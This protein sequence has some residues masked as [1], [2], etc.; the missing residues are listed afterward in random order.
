M[1]IKDG[2]GGR[3][4]ANLYPYE[5]GDLFRIETLAINIGSNDLSG[6]EP[7][8]NRRKGLSVRE[9]SSLFSSG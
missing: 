7:M 2:N 6:S 4:V 8:V 5:I 1:D 3:Y 9:H